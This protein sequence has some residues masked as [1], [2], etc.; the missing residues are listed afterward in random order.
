MHTTFKKQSSAEATVIFGTVGKN[1]KVCLLALIKYKDMLASGSESSTYMWQI[2]NIISK[3]LCLLA[4]CL[5][6]VPSTHL[7]LPQRILRTS[8]HVAALFW[9]ESKNAR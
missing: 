5:Y 9:M 6:G 8:L 1:L 2:G 3:L 7:S 4:L